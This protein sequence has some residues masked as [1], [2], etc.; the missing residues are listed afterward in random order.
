MRKE[1]LKSNKKINRKFCL[2]LASHVGIGIKKE[3]DTPALATSF[4]VQVGPRNLSCYQGTYAFGGEHV[5]SQIVDS[6]NLSFAFDRYLLLKLLRVK[7]H[8]CLE[9]R[10]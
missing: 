3:P 2:L 8:R 10:P 1:T 4:D 5:P 7:D 9:T 6:S